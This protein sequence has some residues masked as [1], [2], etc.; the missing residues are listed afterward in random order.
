MDKNAA[1]VINPVAIIKES[2]S[3]WFKNLFPLVLLYAVNI[4][5]TF[6]LDV[7]KMA[8]GASRADHPSLYTAV[9]LLETLV[10]LICGA[11]VGLVLLEFFKKVTE[12]GRVSF[13]VAASEAKAAASCYLKALGLLVL[14]IFVSVVAATLIL[15]AGRVY[16]AGAGPQGPKLAALLAASTVFVVMVIATA[17]YGFFF[18][19]SPL[20]AAFEKK[21]VIASFK[22]SRARIRGNALRLLVVYLAFAIFYVGTGLLMVFVVGRIG[23]DR[24]LLD[25]VDPV[26]ATL[27]MPLWMV[28]LYVSYKKVTQAK[29]SKNS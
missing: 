28:L 17:W 3:G 5:L 11:F 26:L 10:V 20:V 1:G 2:V 18:S 14:F 29:Q 23:H 12:E 19:L 21:R 4:V 27:F 6:I 24:R 16:Y 25:I 15:V 7:S 8:L 13:L 9:M 22:E